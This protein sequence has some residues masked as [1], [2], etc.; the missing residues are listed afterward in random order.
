VGLAYRRL[1]EYGE[2]LTLRQI[3][4]HLAYG[5][6]SGVGCY[7]AAGRRQEPFKYP[8]ANFL[9]F[10]R[11]FGD[12]ASGPDERSE[13][14]KAVRAIRAIGPGK[15]LVPSLER[16]L[17]TQNK[18]EAVPLLPKGLQPVFDELRSVGCGRISAQGLT[19]AEAR[20]QVRRLLFLFGEFESSS[21]G[22]EY[23][24]TFLNSK[25]LALFEEWQ[26]PERTIGA[27][28]RE[29]YLQKVLHVLQEHFAGLRLP[30]EASAFGDSLYITLNRKGRN[31][32][33]TAQVVLARIS[34]SDFRLTLVPRG[35]NEIS[36]RQDLLLRQGDR[37]SMPTLRLELPF[38]DFV[39]LR[40]TGDIAMAVQ[41]GYLDRLDRFK[42]QLLS[43]ARS[44]VDHDV[45]LIRLQT[46]QRFATQRFSLNDGVLEVVM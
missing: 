1:F 20:R 43:H 45:T 16:R 13:Q 18:T 42:A 41:A 4:A 26:R 32:R 34:R 33:Q 6:T 11:F 23:V 3:T 2:R 37:A 36:V 25:M 40:H 27:L 38:L 39:M 15:H 46:N 22:Q 28:E 44:S 9:F 12:G 19:A 14:L 5:V 10:N 24:G 8:I 31:I 29:T 17:W 30:E 35:W 7:D 21:E